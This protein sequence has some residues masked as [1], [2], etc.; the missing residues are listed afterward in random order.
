MKP[1]DVSSAHEDKPVALLTVL[2]STLKGP[3]PPQPSRARVTS[4]QIS[5][6]INKKKQIADPAHHDKLSRVEGDNQRFYATSS[7]AGILISR[8][9]SFLQFV[10]LLFLCCSVSAFASSQCAVH[11]GTSFKFQGGGVLFPRNNCVFLPYLHPF[12]NLLLFE[13]F[14][15]LC[16]SKSKALY[17]TLFI[18]P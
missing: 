18:L 13:L 17:Y 15:Y 5:S 9:L 1:L 7:D 3:V 2:G 14:P 6:S 8:C 4:H 11:S 12:F 10:L 16:P